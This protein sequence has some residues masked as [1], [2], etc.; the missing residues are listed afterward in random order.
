MVNILIPAFGIELIMKK[1]M[2]KKAKLK[3]HQSQLASRSPLV[4]KL[5]DTAL[6][7]RNKS[8]VSTNKS[9]QAPVLFQTRGRAGIKIHK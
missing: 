6:S 9:I 1:L 7:A 4:T 2:R 8:K 5:A 3:V